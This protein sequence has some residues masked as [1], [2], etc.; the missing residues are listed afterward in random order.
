MLKNASFSKVLLFAVCLS[1]AL[2]VSASAMATVIEGTT[3]TYG[4]TTDVVTETD[5]VWAFKT[6]VKDADCSNPPVYQYTCTICGAK[7]TV[8]EGT[9]NGQHQW[10]EWVVDSQATCTTSGARHRQ[11][12]LNV[13][14]T[15]QQTVPALGH[16]LQWRVTVAAT[17]TSSGTRE[18]YCT[19]CGQV[20]DT[21]TIPQGDHV[22]GPWTTIKQPTCYDAG[23]QTHTCTICGAT[24]N[25]PFGSALGHNWGAWQIITPATCDSNGTRTR[26]CQR[27][28]SHVETEVIPT[29]GHQW[30]AWRRVKEPTFW[31][32]GREERNC[33]VC[34][35]I[36]TRELGTITYPN[37]T[38]CAFGPRLKESNLYPNYSDKWY[39]FTP[40]DASMNGTQ[41]YELVAADAVIVGDVTL[42]I[43]DGYLTIDYSLKGGDAIRVTLEF[44]TVLNRI[45][46]LSSYEPEGLMNLKINRNTPINLAEKFGG[47]THLVLYFCSRCSVRNH[48]AFTSLAYNSSA[49]RALLSTMLALM[50]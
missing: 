20:I 3:T 31:E 27:D 25:A 44:F 13:H 43:R 46:D 18:Q 11:C 38:L 42:T 40:F 14:H 48:P 37:A 4:S 26:V 35:K 5:H 1:L 19:R 50:D 36:E 9:T 21:Q 7:K 30:T 24:Q 8:E 10:G 39:M 17:C 41:T 16:D 12:T 6:L 28:T 47:D 2:C 29:P 23:E 33:T 49:H 45:G 34:G 15:E 22:W 32:T